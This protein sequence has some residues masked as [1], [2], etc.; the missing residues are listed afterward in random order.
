[1]LLLLCIIPTTA[2]VIIAPPCPFLS[3]Q[4]GNV[5][6]VQAH[7]PLDLRLG[8]ARTCQWLLRAPG[9]VTATLLLRELVL[10]PGSFLDIYT[11]H[12]P[13]VPAAE[14]CACNQ[15][16]GPHAVVCV[17]SGVA[18]PAVVFLD[19]CTKRCDSILAE[20][21]EVECPSGV[22]DILNNATKPLYSFWDSQPYPTQLRIKERF[23]LV[24]LVVYGTGNR[25]T[26]SESV[27]SDTRI[28]LGLFDSTH[29][30]CTPGCLLLEGICKDGSCQCPDDRLGAECSVVVHD[31]SPKQQK[32][33]IDQLCLGCWWYARIAPSTRG[34]NT[35]VE[36]VERDHIATNLLLVGGPQLPPVY[37]YYRTQPTLAW[38]RGASS[39]HTIR[40]AHTDAPFYIA[41]LHQ[42]LGSNANPGAGAFGLRVVHSRGPGTWSCIMDCYGRGECQPDGICQCSST[43]VGDY[44]EYSVV[45][46][47]P[48]SDR[49][50]VLRPGEWSYSE[51][52]VQ[53]S[54]QIEFMLHPA[55]QT[56]RAYPLLLIRKVQPPRRKSWAIP[57]ELDAFEFDFADPEGFLVFPGNGQ[58]I[59]IRCT[60]GSYFI[61]VFNL[62][63]GST[64]PRRS[65][66]DLHYTLSVR[67]VP[68]LYCPALRGLTCAGPTVDTQQR[69]CQ[70]HT[71][72]CQCP[73][74]LLGRDCGIQ[75][76]DLG[77][78]LVQDAGP[79]RLH[80][81]PSGARHYYFINLSSISYSNV[82]FRVEQHEIGRVAPLV[83]LARRGAQPSRLN[84]SFYDKHDWGAHREGSRLHTVWINSREWSTRAS[85]GV[86]YFLVAN[87]PD[88]GVDAAY[89]VSVTDWSQKER[90]RLCVSDSASLGSGGCFCPSNKTLADCSSKGVFSL[91][92]DRST[93]E[94]VR[95][96]VVTPETAPVVEPNQWAFWGL[97][98]P[99]RGLD[100]AVALDA[101]SSSRRG[102]APFMVVRGGQVPSSHIG[103]YDFADPQAGQLRSGRQ[104]IIQ[105]ACGVQWGT[106]DEPC[107]SKAETCNRAWPWNPSSPN[108]T[109]WQ[110]AE[111]RECYTGALPNNSG[112][113]W[114]TGWK[115]RQPGM[116]YIGLF[117]DG[118]LATGPLSFYTLR[119][120][121]RGSCGH[122]TRGFLSS[123][124]DPT[125]SIAT[126]DLVC[127]GVVSV[128]EPCS[129]QGECVLVEKDNGT[130]AALLTRCLCPPTR[131]GKACELECPVHPDVPD[132]PCGGHGVCAVIQSHSGRPVVMCNCYPGYAGWAC[133][134]SE[135]VTDGTVGTVNQ[136]EHDEGH[137]GYPFGVYAG[138]CV[139]AIVVSVGSWHCVKHY[140]SR[141]VHRY[142]HL[143]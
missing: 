59:S 77:E 120:W 71:S 86:W 50:G 110:S 66:S 35:L 123:I 99:C 49:V 16:T 36:L 100:I 79:P 106:G 76:V 74:D 113:L 118:R 63:H 34:G 15:G 105:V 85:G 84:F 41:V 87:L 95:R 46:M 23:V 29:G 124:Q 72:T 47:L 140:Y 30:Q 17:D 126:C 54:Q 10:Q 98:L 132:I 116:Y 122:C 138:M 109:G 18:D 21:V 39:V 55:S 143:R 88:S 64:L 44:C 43:A 38:G 112:T 73:P 139:L 97:P 104:A 119:V 80:L 117:N 27:F 135:K 3:I 111:A 94:G 83:L 134:Y 42:R 12:R 26:L 40:V 131:V 102:G 136:E 13:V 25:E 75:A 128:A 4:V 91:P 92:W 68:E 90:D 22:A 37:D 67:A 78:S 57:V 32:V 1:M 58:R 93:A 33:E 2:A 125:A 19:Q 14:D 81:L 61:G 6:D 129:N 121:I 127:P 52:R 133:S 56:P 9:L 96:A 141:V 20:K 82:Q 60:S 53:G 7:I 130:S 24:R 137:G 8:N 31:L 108:G 28:H 65:S 114:S 11:S 45:E 51:V 70:G 107:W 48:G 89:T 69:R 142:R 115:G 101:G 5:T 62:W 103:T